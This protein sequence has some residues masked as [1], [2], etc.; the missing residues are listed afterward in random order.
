LGTLATVA[1]LAV[2]AGAFTAAC[3]TADGTVT[4]AAAAVGISSVSGVGTVL[5]DGHGKAL[6]ANDQDHGADVRCTG[7]CA[8]VWP[9][10]YVSGTTVPAG[11][12]PGVTVVRRPDDGRE[13]LAYRGQPLY[14]FG[15]DMMAG[16]VTGNDITDGFD[17]VTFVWHA[18]A[19]PGGC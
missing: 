12:A 10:A 14:E 13:Q 19:V 9:P 8:Q 5:V 2:L 16:Q 7:L 17:G 18:A 1:G 11:S 4:P 15:L 6:Y 3:G